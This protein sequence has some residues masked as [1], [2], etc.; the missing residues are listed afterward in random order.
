MCA[1]TDALYLRLCKKWRRKL[2]SGEVDYFDL[3]FDVLHFY[4]MRNEPDIKVSNLV[5]SFLGLQD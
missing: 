3:W 5:T 1:T 4:V 2:G